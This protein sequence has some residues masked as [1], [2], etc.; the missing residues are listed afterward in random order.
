M[1]ILETIKTRR[2]IRR[3]T[4][5]EVEDQL[6][7]RILEAGRWAPSGHNNQPWQWIIVKNRSTIE[8]IARC[9]IYGEVV[10]SANALIC[11]FLDK[12][13]VYDLKKDTLAIGACIQNMCLAAH[14]LG[15]GCCWQGEILARKEEVGR[16]L[17]APDSL[18]L[19]AVLTLGYPAEG[20][21]SGRKKLSKIAHKERY[22]FPWK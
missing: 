5:K 21:K 20:G 15:L 12:K 22:G 3:Y 10:R 16:I 19:V 14:S 11:V 1:D 13:E 2:S 6:I 8:R 4:R 9:T 17:E 18:E 7:E